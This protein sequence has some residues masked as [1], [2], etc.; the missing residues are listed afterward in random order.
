MVLCA[1]AGAARPAAAAPTP[2]E[3]D[4][5]TLLAQQQQQQ[6]MILDQL[7]QQQKFQQM[8]YELTIKRN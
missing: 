6:Q 4:I 7:S 2:A 8:L 3:P 1:T 5:R